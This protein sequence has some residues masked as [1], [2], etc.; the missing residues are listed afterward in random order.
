MVLLVLR[1]GAL[2]QGAGQGAHPPATVIRNCQ[3]VEDPPVILQGQEVQEDGQ[4]VME[5]GQEAMDEDQEAMEED[6]E[7]L[8]KGREVSLDGPRAQVG[9]LEARYGDQGVHDGDQEALD[10]GAGQALLKG[11]HGGEAQVEEGL[12][13]TRLTG[14]QV[15]HPHQ[16]HV[17]PPLR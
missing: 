16:G 2:D 10:Q 4:E 8:Q 14:D 12:P 3:L 17:A 6:Q 15:H 5:E 13:P 11:G 9:G 7:H 1:Q